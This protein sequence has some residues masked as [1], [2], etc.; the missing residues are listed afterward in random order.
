MDRDEFFNVPANGSGADRGA[1]SPSRDA[2]GWTPLCPM[3]SDAPKSPHVGDP[4]LSV[5]SG[6]SFA[7]PSNKF[8]PYRD[9]DG[10]LLGYV[11]RIERRSGG[12]E[13]RPWTYCEHADGRRE[14]R[15]KALPAPRPLYGLDRLAIAP[16]APVLIVEGEKAADAAASLFPGFISVTSS[17]GARAAAKADFSSLAGR[18]VVIWPDHDADGR[19][20]AMEVARFARA[21]GAQRVAIVTVP[22][23][24]PAKW[25][26][27]DPLPD[28]WT[29]ERLLERLQAAMWTADPFAG[30]DPAAGV[31][32]P[33][34]LSDT[35]VEYYEERENHEGRWV[36]ICV[37]RFEI[38]A[39]TRSA[40]NEDWGRLGRITDPDGHAHILALPMSQLGGDGVALR[41][42]LLGMGLTLPNARAR[43]RLA[44]YIASTTPPLRVR[45][46]PRIGWH[47]DCYVL[48]DRTFGD[49]AEPVFLQTESAMDHRFGVVGDLAGWR[50]EVARPCIGNSRLVFA[51]SLAFAPPLLR[52]FGAEGGGF[53]F[54]GSSSIGKSTALRVAASVWGSGT[55]KGVIRTWRATSNG[56]EAVALASND[57]LLCLDELGE[58]DGREAGPTAYM[59]ANGEG[60]TRARRDGSGRPPARWLTQFLST[61]EVSLA[62][63]MAEAGRMVQAGQEARF[64]DL[65]ADAKA[66]LGAFDALNG[67]ASGDALARHLNAATSC[68]HGAPIRVYLDRLCADLSGAMDDVKRDAKRFVTELC[69]RETDGQV[70]RVAHRFG[71]IAAAGALA[72][73]FGI[74]PWLERECFDAAQL[75]FEEWLDNRGGAGAAEAI[76]VLRLIRRFIEEHG[77][78]RFARIDA[79][80]SDRPT[81]NR[82]G[83]RRERDER[84]E[85]LFL[86]T[87]FNDVCP[88]ITLRLVSE[89]L[90]EAGC[91]VM[92]AGG[93]AS[94][95]VKVP[96]LGTV[97][98]YCIDYQALCEA[99]GGAGKPE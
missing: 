75:L 82:A 37:P 59:L 7:A 93:K 48:P 87:A 9:A 44:E 80:A 22:T 6:E 40:E 62:D 15:L 23:E 81:F 42:R 97:R 8:F 31:Q 63:K 28:G 92:H 49:A 58:L 24:F 2:D 19:R 1:G 32:H 11:E 89:A 27:A 25:D 30:L 77:D 84:T 61:G 4:P 76:R 35:G 33:F 55:A 78:D 41:E 36:P 57:A 16:N 72:C 73:R 83:F 29:R 20:Y 60:K 88:G 95:A 45:C 43:V 71:L 85:Y 12:K 3:P 90:R 51:L 50:E 17:G 47:D 54:R 46:V 39:Y 26:L 56:L 70:Q 86:P 64:I 91:L 34:R 96:T 21:A 66:G 68:N 79:V 5:G 99:I 53:H 10:R 67:F 94:I 52:R 18:N 69:S 98:V 65:E 14:W 13:F 38:L 74:L